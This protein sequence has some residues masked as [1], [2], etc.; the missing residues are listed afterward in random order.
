MF[1]TNG[2]RQTTP[3][4]SPQP[5]WAL[6]GILEGPRDLLAGWTERKGKKILDARLFEDSQHWWNGTKGDEAERGGE[7]ESGEEVSDSLGV[8]TPSENTGDFAPLLSPLAS[9]EPV[10]DPAALVGVGVGYASSCVETLLHAGT[11]A[12][13]THGMLAGCDEGD[14]ESG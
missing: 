12:D 5:V 4:D 6:F 7:R 9:L 14:S 13:D 8:V 10:F 3:S 1:Q 11:L 2:S